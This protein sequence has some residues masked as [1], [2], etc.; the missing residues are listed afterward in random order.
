MQCRKEAS[1]TL[2][3]FHA[4]FRDCVREMKATTQT[5]S[6]P[7]QAIRFIDS[8]DNSNFYEFKRMVENGPALGV[9]Y[10]ATLAAALE[11]ANNFVPPSTS[12]KPTH[13]R[14]NT[15]AVYK[16]QK[17]EPK[18]ASVQGQE[19]KGAKE[20]APEQARFPYKCH[21]CH[22]VGH[23]AKDCRNLKKAAYHVKA[24][25][26]NEEEE[27]DM[28]PYDILRNY[29]VRVYATRK[30]DETQIVLDN[31][32]QVSIFSN[33]N[34]LED[35]I[36]TSPIRV[37]GLSV[38]DNGILCTRSGTFP[39]LGKVKVFISP[40]SNIN[41][42]CLG[43]VTSAGY[44]I[45]W[46]QRNDLFTVTD[47][48]GDELKFGRQENL[49]TL[50]P[51]KKRV[52]TT[53][54]EIEKATLVKDIQKRL[55]YESAGGLA[56]AVR[57]GSISNLPITLHDIHQ[58]EKIFGPSVAEIKGKRTQ[59]KAPYVQE[60]EVQKSED[61][62]QDLHI[63]IMFVQKEAFLVSVGDPIDLTM[64]DPL[65]IN[66]NQGKNAERILEVIMAHVSSYWT[67]GFNVKTI[68]SDGEG[69]IRS[70]EKDLKR[71]GIKL[72]TSGPNRHVV[73]KVDRRIRMIK[74]RVRSIIHGLPYFL[75]P[76]LMKY[77]VQDQPDQTQ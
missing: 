17:S 69:G 25:A 29:A 43:D 63:D 42:L 28:N 10:P 50:I 53:Q 54:K 38:E 3:Q 26:A 64:V 24:E 72:I 66:S 5:V 71:V 16:T 57:E 4:R 48:N 55:G 75:P 35:I 45:D 12:F 56:R 76:S 14:E 58:A 2:A 51:K 32:A 61:K 65:K 6:E 34:L 18:K 74:E 21:N 9:A 59:R 19:R 27:D 41:I 40:K 1:E 67:Q 23:K 60:S 33:E 46:N 36:E 37:H 15:V 68:H 70:I 49:Y 7:S 77:C 62:F 47:D 20:A 8:L 44:A 30:E 52:M 11:A 13:H 39:G 73:P 31:C 22:K